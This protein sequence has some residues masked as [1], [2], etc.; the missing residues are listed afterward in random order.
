M[1]HFTNGPAANQTLVL[2]RA[3]IFLR[4]T[5]DP[6]NQIDA[7]DQLTDEPRPDEKLYAYRRQQKP[8]LAHIKMT[9]KKRSG[10]YLVANYELEPVQPSDQ[11]MR[12]T[13]AWQQW[14]QERNRIKRKENNE[15]IPPP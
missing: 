7:L 8:L 6:K 3:P 1:I 2:K 4:V 5:I 14:C 12:D 15:T 13:T 9:P 10:F 11:T